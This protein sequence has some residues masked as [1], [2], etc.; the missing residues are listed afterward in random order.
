MPA[1][2][3]VAGRGQEGKLQTAVGVGVKLELCLVLASQA[4]P[5]PSSLLL[6]LWGKAALASYKFHQYKYEECGDEC[7]EVFIPEE[8]A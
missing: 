5:Q 4:E 3:R 8:R 7:E 1:F 6:A 2:I